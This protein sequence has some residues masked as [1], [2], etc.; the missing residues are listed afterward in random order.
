MQ[1]SEV[2]LQK[3]NEPNFKTT[4][5]NLLELSPTNYNFFKYFYNFPQEMV[6]NNNSPNEYSNSR[7]SE[8]YT[9]K[10]LTAGKNT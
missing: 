7:T 9:I 5:S 10:I 2:I 6:F 1:V 4:S 8:V 3:L